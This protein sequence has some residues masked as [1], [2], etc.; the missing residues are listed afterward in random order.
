MR[1][2]RE[3]SVIRSFAGQGKAMKGTADRDDISQVGQP[4]QLNLIK[5]PQHCVF[6]VRKE[7]Q[8]IK[9][10]LKTLL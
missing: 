10:L 4:P 1:T 9:Y 2:Q 3:V 7:G 8:E 6:N 5:N